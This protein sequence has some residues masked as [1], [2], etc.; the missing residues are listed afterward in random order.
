MLPTHMSFTVFSTFQVSLF[1]NHDTLDAHLPSTG[2]I[3]G[4]FCIDYM[5]PKATMVSGINL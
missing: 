3:L 2:T 5:G 1:D 4:A